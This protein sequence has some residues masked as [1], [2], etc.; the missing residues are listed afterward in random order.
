MDRPDYDDL[1]FNA[2]R[3]MEETL[4]LLKCS[5][6]NKLTTAKVKV[7]CKEKLASLFV[8]A[9]HFMSKEYDQ[10]TDMKNSSEELKTELIT[11][12]KNVIQLQSELLVN[13]TEQLQSLQ[14]TVKTSVQDT[15][16]AEFVSYSAAVQKTQ[17]L[18][19]A[20]DHLKTVVRNVV[21]EEDRSRS[22]M[23][24]GL[25]E[26]ADEQLCDKIGDVFQEIGEKPRIEAK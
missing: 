1:R 14:T 16:K 23:V 7:Q 11:C 9:L 24:F 4:D 8:D 21:E 22:V 2:G 12:Q 6:A 17:T 15:V 26:S 13:K 20:P 5:D 10:L 18:V 3:W 19:L 25:P